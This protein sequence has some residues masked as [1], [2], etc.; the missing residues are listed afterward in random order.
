MGIQ[1]VLTAARSPWQNAFA[2]HL[3]GS[4]RRDH[5]R[6]KHRK[7]EVS[8]ERRHIADR[9]MKAFP[10]IDFFEKKRKPFDDILV[11]FVVSEM[12]LLIFTDA[13]GSMDDRLTYCFD[14]A[15]ATVR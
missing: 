10:V 15:S 13:R 6:L 11:S 2:E 8:F 4:I 3:I 1:E 5:G 7:E 9:G 12:H 14:N